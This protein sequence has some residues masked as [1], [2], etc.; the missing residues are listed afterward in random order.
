MVNQAV[1]HSFSQYYARK[2]K[3]VS[4]SHDSS[5]IGHPVFSTFDI[6]PY[7]LEVSTEERNEQSQ[8]E[9][10][11]GGDWIIRFTKHLFKDGSQHDKNRTS[12]TI[13]RNFLEAWIPG[14]GRV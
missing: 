4:D 3:I 9:R 14:M 12:D 6:E 11:L 13:T 1:R 10:E 5:Y 2:S 8:L 7:A